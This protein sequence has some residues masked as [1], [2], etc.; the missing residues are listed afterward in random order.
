MICLSHRHDSLYNLYHPSG[1]LNA[2]KLTA[3]MDPHL[4]VTVRL[5]GELYFKNTLLSL[6]RFSD[7][8]LRAALQNIDHHEQQHHLHLWMNLYHFSAYHP[9]H[10]RD[11]KRWD[12]DWSDC[13]R[14]LLICLKCEQGTIPQ[15]LKHKRF[16]KKTL[17]Q[18]SHTHRK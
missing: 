2:L 10:W 9:M 7:E 17:R 18:H 12:A 8:E 15:R 1:Y 13:A 14:V 4:L 6:S 3:D 11:S 16:G 5:H